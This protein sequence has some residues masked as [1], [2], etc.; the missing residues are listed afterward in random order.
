MTET[1]IMLPGIILPAG[2]AYSD[3]VACLGEEFHVLTKDL[4]VYAGDEPPPGYGLGTEIAGV[5][6]VAD[7]RGVDRFHLVGYSAGGA[8]SFA[9]TVRHPHRVSTLALLEPAWLGNAGMGP[10]ERRVSEALDRAATLPPEQMLAEFTRLQLA[11]GVESPARPV[12]PPPDWMRKRPAAIRAILHAFAESDAELEM[13]G[14]SE[15]PVY[16][17]LGG[18]SNPDSFGEMATRCR[19]AV[20]NARVEVFDERHHFDPPH[21]VEPDRL[22]A[23]LRAL[24]R[25]VPN[26]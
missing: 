15:V 23:S 21:R 11:P 6:D 5:L 1:V 25:S 24:W 26:G 7:R 8:A 9:F 19:S 22:A 18:R 17:A 13:L 16:Y 12:G 20:P 10:S 4:E 2:E 3:L 14:T